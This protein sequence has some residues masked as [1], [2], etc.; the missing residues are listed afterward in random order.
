MQHWS[1]QFLKLLFLCKQENV[2]DRQIYILTHY[3]DL[4]VCEFDFAGVC[5][6]LYIIGKT[7]CDKAFQSVVFTW[8]Q[9]SSTNKTGYHNSTENT[10]E[11]WHLYYQDLTS[12]TKMITSFISIILELV[13]IILEPVWIILEP[14]WLDFYSASWPKLST[15]RHI[16]PFGHNTL[17]PSQPVFVLTPSLRM[18]SSEAVNTNYSEH[19]NHYVINVV[20]IHVYHFQHAIYIVDFTIIFWAIHQP[21]TSYRQTGL[22]TLNSMIWNKSI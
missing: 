16:A 11:D 17:N 18:L 22:W 6:Y 19:I 3:T 7:W 13:W 14:V 21:S 20:Y 9:V 15:G 1:K 8:N 5:Y 4:G 12:Y 2:V 10:V